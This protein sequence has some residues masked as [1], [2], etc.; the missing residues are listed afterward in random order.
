M[1]LKRTLVSM[2]LE[3]YQRC[4]NRIDDYLEYAWRAEMSMEALRDRIRDE[5]A[6]LTRDLVRA[7]EDYYSERE[8]G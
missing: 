6:E 7:T 5:F 4:V 8:E 2:Q 1:E 3:A